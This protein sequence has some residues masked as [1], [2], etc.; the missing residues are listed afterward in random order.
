MFDSG[1]VRILSFGYM[2]ANLAQNVKN[3][4]QNA[5]LLSMIKF[6][7]RDVIYS[8]ISSYAKAM[9]H[10]SPVKR[11]ECMFPFVNHPLSR[12]RKLILKLQPY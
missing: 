4:G 2:E 7:F 12:M 9:H 10:Q 3:S 5:L 8:G 6:F 11:P 1:V